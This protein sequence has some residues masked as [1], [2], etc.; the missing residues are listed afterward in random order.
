M[1]EPLVS[2]L[3]PCYNAA[4]FLAETLECALAQ[5]WPHVEIIVVDDGSRDAS[6]AIAQGFGARG[7]KLFT[8]P[9]SGASAARNHAFRVSRGDFI[10]YLDADDLISPG[11]IAAQMALLARCPVGALATCA[12][13]RFY[14]DPQE[15]RFLDALVCRDFTGVEF[16][17]LAGDT[18][19]MMH[20]SAWLVPRHVIACA[21]P[22]D[23]RL[24]LNDDGEFFSR[25]VL[26]ASGMQFCGDPAAKS[27]YRSGLT[28]SLSKQRH[29]AARRSQYLSLDLLTTALLRAEDS[30]RTRRAAAG[31]WRRY[32][33]EFFPSPPE[34][35][36]RAEAAV[37][38][39]G[40]DLGPPV[41]GRKSALLANF[42]GWR[43]VARLKYL[44][45]Q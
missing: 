11:K 17:V 7:V 30:P 27:Y 37:Q 20:P 28:G 10:Q 41:L 45:G 22:W 36:N 16:L 42:I 25:V 3:I 33:H 44:L 43:N 1:P 34:L 26:A 21:G 8:Q 6:R 24:T 9:N 40:E 39:L 2:I 4:P 14:R 38:Q 29:D 5:T 19:T 31:Y 13:G 35:V 12:W 23:E 18:G 15:A 32:V